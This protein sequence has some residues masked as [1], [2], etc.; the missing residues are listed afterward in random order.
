MIVQNYIKGQSPF[1]VKMRGSRKAINR[2]GNH[3][4]KLSNSMKKLVMLFVLA[5]VASWGYSQKTVPTND[6]GLRNG[7]TDYRRSNG[8]VNTY[9]SVMYSSAQSSAYKQA[10]D[11]GWSRCQSSS[12]WI[13]KNGKLVYYEKPDY[14][15]G[16]KLPGHQKP[17]VITVHSSQPAKKQ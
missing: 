14:G 2:V 11:L 7:C 1:A 4:S 10:Y 6:M 16:P 15:K 12:N 17:W 13:I 5:F 9:N 8:N 3:K